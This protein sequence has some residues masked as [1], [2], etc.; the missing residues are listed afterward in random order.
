[1]LVYDVADRGSFDALESWINEMKNEIDNPSDIDNI[2]FVVC[3]N[4]VRFY[5]P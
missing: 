5:R 4:K 3:A 2:V 1:M